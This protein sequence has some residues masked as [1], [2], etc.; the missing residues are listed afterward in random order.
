MGGLRGVGA[1]E[2]DDPSAPEHAAGVGAWSGQGREVARGDAAIGGKLEEMDVAMVRGGVAATD[3]EQALG[4]GEADPVGG[5]S[6]QGADATPGAAGFQGIE[7][8]DAVMPDFGAA[9]PGLSAGEIGATGDE[10][11]VAVDAGEGR[12]KAMGIGQVRKAGPVGGRGGE[13]DEKED[14]EAVKH[15]RIRTWL[16]RAGLRGFK[17]GLGAIAA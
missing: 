15:A 4:Q 2:D 12:G 10:E 14:E 5:G 3:A 9:F 7:G 17:A 16:G 11:V 13:G 6:R 1:A 8:E